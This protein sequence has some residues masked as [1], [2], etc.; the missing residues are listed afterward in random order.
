[1]CFIFKPRAISQAGRRGFDPRLP[2]F[3]FSN[4]GGLGVFNVTAIT[5]F[6]P[7][8]HGRGRRVFTAPSGHL[9]K[10]LAVDCSGKHHED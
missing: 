1:M 2:L 6:S 7:N 4:F 10:F 3:P 5:A 8:P 9:S